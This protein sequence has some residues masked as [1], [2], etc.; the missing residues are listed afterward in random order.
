MSRRVFWAVGSAAL[1]AGCILAMLALPAGAQSGGSEG[2]A[3]ETPQQAERA[4]AKAATTQPAPAPPPQREIATVRFEATIFQVAVTPEHMTDL[5]TKALTAE[6]ASPAKLAQALQKLGE[7]KVLY[8]VDQTVFADGGRQGKIEIAQDTPYV[9]GMQK[10]GGGEN[11]PNISRQHLGANFDVFAVVP[12][13][14]PAGRVHA[15]VKVDVSAMTQSNVSPSSDTTAP[16]FWRVSQS[17]GGLT[18]LGKPI[19]LLS[20]DGSRGGGTSAST[21]FVTLL[22]L[23]AP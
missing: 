20:A 15:T 10:G 5:D 6:A 9:A 7:T 12:D 1:C 18:D 17:Y 22:Q 23:T 14:A 19:V 3:R 8:R 11:V 4:P 2:K 13:G 16:T 21:A